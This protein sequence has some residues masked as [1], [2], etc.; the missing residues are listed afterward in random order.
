MATEHVAME[1]GRS[2]L[3]DHLTKMTVTL[4]VTGPV[5]LLWV[6]QNPQFSILLGSF[7][8]LQLNMSKVPYLLVICV[9]L[10][11]QCAVKPT[12]VSPI[13]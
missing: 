8:R 6:V 12:C 3:R 2:A 1:L 5:D 4:H 7:V 13:S 11:C 10:I 9:L